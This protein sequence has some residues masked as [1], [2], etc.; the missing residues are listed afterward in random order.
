MSDT[1][2]TIAANVTSSFGNLTNL[3]TAGSYAAGAMFSVA[4]IEEFKLH[5]DDPT[6]VPVG[7][8]IALLF[9]AAALTFASAATTK[10][11]S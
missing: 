7:T 3:I 5:A 1:V 2:G 4:Q 10:G 8:P 11:G 9:A 6:Q